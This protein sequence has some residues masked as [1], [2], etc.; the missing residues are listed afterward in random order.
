MMIISLLKASAISISTALTVAWIPGMRPKGGVLSDS[1]SRCVLG[2]GTNLQ[3]LLSHRIAT[4]CSIAKVLDE[5]VLQQCIS[6]PEESG[7]HTTHHR[8]EDYDK[9]G[10]GS[11]T[12]RWSSG[13]KLQ[14]PVVHK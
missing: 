9:H 8:V 6:I 14:V 13:C 5:R 3:S 2:P 1:R 11:V 7:K 12:N 4:R 10:G